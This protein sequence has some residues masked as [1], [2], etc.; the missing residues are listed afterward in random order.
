MNQ[1]NPLSHRRNL[2][3]AFLAW[4]VTMA[5]PLVRATAPTSPETKPGIKIQEALKS[6]FSL[7]SGFEYTTGTYGLENNTQTITT[8]LT[9]EYVHRD[10]TIRGY[11]P[12]E[13]VK[14]P[15]GITIINGRPAATLGASNQNGMLQRLGLTA[16]QNWALTPRQ[17]QARVDAAN[18]PSETNS[19]IGDVELSVDYD[20]YNDGKAGWD[21]SLNG[22]IKLGTG[23]TTKGLGTGETDYRLSA[24]VSRGI[25][26]F[27]PYV[28]FGYC[29]AGKP[30]DS[31]LLNYYFGNAGVGYS[32]TNST[33]VNLAFSATQRYS[34]STGDDHEASLTVSHRIDRSW[35]VEG[36]VLVGVSAS[37]PDFGAGASFRYWF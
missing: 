33:D 29:L 22:T 24:T 9:A 2:F 6:E 12:Y 23:S 32:I 19:G 4:F 17:R 30:A 36:H 37:A 18:T 8:S 5:S 35:D 10:W 20:A 16:T 15:G 14:S 11:I 34:E 27:T 7:L 26:R 28:S 13:Y 21:I 3:I 31:D 1:M 25:K